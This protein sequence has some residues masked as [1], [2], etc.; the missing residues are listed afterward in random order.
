[1]NTYEQQFESEPSAEKLDEIK[2]LLKSE[3]AG[4]AWE[5]YYWGAKCIV[6]YDTEDF[7]P[8]LLSRAMNAALKYGLS[9]I[10]LNMPC[11]PPL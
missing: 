7:E 8:G 6:K 2:R 9:L 4:T 3:T 10:F 5:T 1:M 11:S